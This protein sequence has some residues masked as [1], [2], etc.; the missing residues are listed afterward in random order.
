MRKFNKRADMDAFVQEFFGSPL[1]DASAKINT[2][3]SVKARFI[4]ML[5][6]EEDSEIMASMASNYAANALQHFVAEG[7]VDVNDSQDLSN[8][9]TFGILVMGVWFGWMLKVKQI[10]DKPWNLDFSDFAKT[11]ANNCL[12]QPKDDNDSQPA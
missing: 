9:A 12:E 2:F 6:N 1:D 10:R 8:T 5:R 7:L 11:E 3:E 4:E